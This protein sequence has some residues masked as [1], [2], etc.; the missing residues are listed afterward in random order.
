M[1][2]QKEKEQE[3]DRPRRPRTDTWTVVPDKAA[4]LIPL[5]PPGCEAREHTLHLT[6]HR[7]GS[8]NRRGKGRPLVKLSPHR[9]TPIFPP[10]TPHP[11]PSSSFH[12]LSRRE[13]LHI[14]LP[15]TTLPVWLC[16][17]LFRGVTHWAHHPRIVRESHLSL[18]V[19]PPLLDSW[20]QLLLGDVVGELIGPS[21]HPGEGR[22]GGK[23][24]LSDYRPFPQRHHLPQPSARSSH[25]LTSLPQMTWRISS[26]N[27]RP[28]LLLAGPWDVRGGRKQEP[29]V[30][31]RG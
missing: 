16:P 10:L 19:P 20:E 11:L 4:S 15:Q 8:L 24:M 30:E 29:E 28:V 22:A 23:E 21:I 27:T 17:N 14:A 3:A 31:Q 18:P 6:V 9:E 5:P 25:A 12:P 1:E 26:C 7:L 2:R 13:K